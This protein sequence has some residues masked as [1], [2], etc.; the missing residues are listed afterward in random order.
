[1]RRYGFRAARQRIEDLKIIY[2]Q[3]R[4][5]CHTDGTWD[6]W[7]EAEIAELEEEIAAAHQGRKCKMTVVQDGHSANSIG[8]DF[9]PIIPAWENACN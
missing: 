5:S 6:W 3:M 7:I 8:I 4:R 1:M 2:R 9:N